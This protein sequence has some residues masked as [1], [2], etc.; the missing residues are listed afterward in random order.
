MFWKQRVKVKWLK[1]GDKNTS[2]FHVSAHLKRNKAKI[3]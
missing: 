3:F 2:L 1:E